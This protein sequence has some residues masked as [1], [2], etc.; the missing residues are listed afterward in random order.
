MKDV[1]VLF[2]GTRIEL[3]DYSSIDNLMHIAENDAS[4]VAICD[5]IT[6]E[7]ISRV[8]MFHGDDRIALYRNLIIA[9]PPIR[10]TNEDGTVTVVIFLRERTSVEARLDA[11]EES[12]SVQNGAIE[13]LGLA[14]SDIAEG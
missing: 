6:S 8:E 3:E 2:D 14:I 1:L 9:K 10:Y 13:D 4:A 7:N 5:K 11:L 12:D